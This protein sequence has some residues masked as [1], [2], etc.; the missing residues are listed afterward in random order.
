M[1][2]FLSFS[3]GH[4]T[5][6]ANHNPLSLARQAVQLHTSLVKRVKKIQGD[7]SAVII[8]ISSHYLVFVSFRPRGEV[9][10]VSRFKS[11]HSSL[12]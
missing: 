11:I 12:F 8:I 6:S 4:V 3:G 2:V 5:N 10:K 7:V 9:V 1:S